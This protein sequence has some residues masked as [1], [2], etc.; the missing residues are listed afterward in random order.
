[1][2]YNLE[3]DTP[4]NIKEMSLSDL[5]TWA[6]DR[7]LPA[8]LSTGLSYAP[9]VEFSPSKVAVI[10]K[11]ICKRFHKPID[12]D[13]EQMLF[14]LDDGKRVLCE[15]SAGAGKTTVSQL[16]L[17]K[18]K[19]FYGISGRDILSIAY[20][21]HAV[22]DMIARH[23]QLI[24]EINNTHLTAITSKDARDLAPAGVEPEEPSAIKL[25]YF[26]PC[27]TFHKNAMVWLNHFKSK[28]HLTTIG[29]IEANILDTKDEQT[30]MQRAL[31]A[32]IKTE[33]DEELQAGKPLTSFFKPQ[34]T[35]LLIKWKSYMEVTMLEE[36]EWD[37]YPQFNEIGLDPM[38]VNLIFNKYNALCKTHSKIQM[39]ETLI[40]F[41]NLLRDDEEV[42][43][44]V[45]EA[46]KV[47]LIDEYQDMSP[48]MNNIIELMVGED[49]ILNVIGDGDQ[50]IYAF[51]GTDSLNCLKFKQTFNNGRVL[52]MGANRRCRSNIV[53][54]AKHLL[55]LNTLRYKKDL[56]STKEGGT[57]RTIPYNTS[58]EQANFIL[59]EL[60]GLTKE[61]LNNTCI[62]FRN[63]AS[64]DLLAK[65]LLDNN[66]P[67]TVSEGHVPYRDILS[68][69]IHNMFQF[70]DMPKST[71]LHLTVLPTVL[72]ASKQQVYN[73]IKESMKG[74][75]KNTL[76][77][78]EY[79]WELLNSSLAAKVRNVIDQ[80]LEYRREMKSGASMADLFPKM[81]RLCSMYY[82]NWVKEQRNFSS[83]LEQI[84]KE[85]F[86]V[87]KPYKQFLN[88]YLKMMEAKSKLITV[89]GRKT[90]EKHI[91]QQG[92]LLATFHKLK[93]LEFDRV[94]LIDLEDSIFPNYSKIE[95]DFE[96]N[97]E[98]ILNMKEECVRLFYVACTRPKDELVLCYNKA[99]P[100]C[101]LPMIVEGIHIREEVR[102]REEEEK[103][104]RE[105]DDT[106]NIDLTDDMIIESEESDVDADLPI[107][108]LPIPDLP[109]PDLTI[110]EPEPVILNEDE[111]GEDEDTKVDSE[112][113]AILLSGFSP[114]INLNAGTSDLQ[115]LTANPKEESLPVSEEEDDEG[116]GSG[117]GLEEE[118]P[119]EP[120][121][122]IS[123]EGASLLSRKIGLLNLFK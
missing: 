95:R 35:P 96:G 111:D 13:N 83:E 5:T 45:Q 32:V 121:T 31:E 11:N 25:D 60:K 38:T 23:E 43:K 98:M 20:N 73:V 26:L 108:D 123:E 79:N 82:W 87:N 74:K 53:N 28:C 55:D 19:L 70:L 2:D 97:P 37:T 21:D 57:I 107:P 71:S 14:L 77:F 84:I 76:S 113:G 7:V 64:A 22:A 80:L 89:S 46:Y 120:Y 39:T 50:S 27:R 92:V 24:A 15:A 42:R 114:S 109:I 122:S 54:A 34:T 1:M 12:L 66:I 110:P 104:M 33:H 17:V 6:G 61:E 47:I 59:S 116:N 75:E 40:L 4:K 78:D 85:D 100:T 44:T 29:D 102:K 56:Y 18:Y 88:D 3:L 119:Y 115:A 86:I 9:K 36:S 65:V 103:K 63:N 16:K 90:K 101:Y 8:H 91:G 81:M 10:F 51:N 48:L 106:F 105:V 118:D 112:M 58:V 52:S 94:Y 68:T 69:M 117:D 62:A 30:L 99:N 93:G 49:T 41:R 67:I 72:P